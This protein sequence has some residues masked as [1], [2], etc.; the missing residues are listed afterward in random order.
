MQSYV[1]DLCKVVVADLDDSPHAHSPAFVF[2]LEC[3][4]I[5]ANVKHAQFDWTQLVDTTGMHEVI[6]RTLTGE[7]PD[8]QGEKFG[9]L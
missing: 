3:L 7:S 9:S 4:T 2:A 8:Y 6:M 5:V 1:G